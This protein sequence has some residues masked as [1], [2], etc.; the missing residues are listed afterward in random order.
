MENHLNEKGKK[1]YSC[2]GFA[3]TEDYSAKRTKECSKDLGSCIKSN[4]NKPHQ[5][6]AQLEDQFCSQ[7]IKKIAIIVVNMG[8][9]GTKDDVK[10]KLRRQHR[11]LYFRQV[12]SSFVSGMAGKQTRDLGSWKIRKQMQKQILNVNKLGFD[13]SLIW[14]VK[15]DYFSLFKFCRNGR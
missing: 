1:T 14:H 12:V 2:N 3:I 15:F 9:D 5:V 8:T 6:L 7:K 10:M 13:H 11:L 4:Q